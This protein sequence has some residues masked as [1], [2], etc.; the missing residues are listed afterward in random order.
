MHPFCYLSLNGRLVG[1]IFGRKGYVELGLEGAADVMMELNRRIGV[2]RHHLFLMTICA[3]KG[4]N[5][6]ND[7]FH[8]T[9]EELLDFIEI[10]LAEN[11]FKL[12]ISQ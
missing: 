9:D 3:W 6:F 10:S 7:F 11:N 4:W 1:L 2:D 5:L 12:N 8:L